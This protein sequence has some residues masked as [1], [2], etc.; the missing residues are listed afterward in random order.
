MLFPTLIFGGDKDHPYSHAINGLP[1]AIK[2]AGL[3]RFF[4]FDGSFHFI[5][6]ADIAK[7]VVCL[8]KNDVPEKDI[9][10]GQAPITFNKMIEVLCRIAKK[11]IYFRITITPK[12]MLRLAKI[13]RVKI[14]SWDKYCLENPGLDRYGVELT[15]PL[16]ADIEIGPSWGDKEKWDD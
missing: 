8:L 4:G 3:F 10:L 14:N 15:V 12:F 6:A 7:M 5:H 11:K 1:K 9:V 16:V 2:W 13:M